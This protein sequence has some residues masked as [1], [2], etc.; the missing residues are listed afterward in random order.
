VAEGKIR[1]NA[2]RAQVAALALEDAAR[3]EG[4]SAGVPGSPPRPHKY[5]RDWMCEYPNSSVTPYPK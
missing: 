4:A 1:L 3:A 5:G 2:L